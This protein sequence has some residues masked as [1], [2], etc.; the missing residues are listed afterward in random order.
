MMLTSILGVMQNYYEQII[1]GG[2]PDQLPLKLSFAETIYNVLISLLGPLAQIV[3]TF[4]GPRYTFMISV[5]VSSL[6]LLLASFSTQVWHLYLTHGA[7]YGTGISLMFYLA[8][9]IVP[10]HFEKHR[11][12][13]L[14]L[15]TS[16]INVGGL[17]FPSIMDPINTRFGAA[18]CYRVMSLICFTVGMLACFILSLKENKNSNK[19]KLTPLREIFD[20]SVAK[21]WRYML[22]C[23]A[24]IFLEAAYHTPSYYIPSYATYLGLSSA[25][26]ALIL[27]VG[28][29]MNA[30][31]KISSGILADYLGHLNV[32]ILYSSLS[33]ISAL[34]IWRYATTFE[35][36]LAFV[37]IYGFFGSAFITLTP[38]ITMHVTGKEKFETG[39]SVFL[40]I[41]VVSMFGPNVA[42]FIESTTHEKKP[43]ESYKYFTGIGYA[44]GVLLMIAFRFTLKK[45]VFVIL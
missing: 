27:S 45:K 1:F 17:V 32:A 6:G 36:F 9:T 19:I 43:F 12:I 14:G 40:V 4:V 42:G 15:A 13:A 26:G 34:I 41:T 18:W 5:S 16:G 37:I 22:W 2:N 7:V 28:E 35:T 44:V 11:G 39:L 33:G 10:E 21:D 24:D 38:A 23:I 8:F 30:M 31:G 29:G 20:F 25:Q 3:L